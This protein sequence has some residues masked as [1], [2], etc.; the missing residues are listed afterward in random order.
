MK[1]L[2]IECLIPFCYLEY[3]HTNLLQRKFW[4]WKTIWIQ[5]LPLFPVYWLHSIFHRKYCGWLWKKTNWNLLSPWRFD[6]EKC[7]QDWMFGLQSLFCYRRIPR[8]C[9]LEVDKLKICIKVCLLK[10]S[11]IYNIIMVLIKQQ[12]RVSWTK[13]SLIQ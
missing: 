13:I 7:L 8:S 6:C 1:N 12:L 3:V 5:K 9:W 10:N 2:V 4:I 11:Q